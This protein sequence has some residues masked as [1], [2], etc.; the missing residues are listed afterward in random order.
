[1]FHQDLFQRGCHVLLVENN[2]EEEDEPDQAE[3]ED[4]ELKSALNINP[5]SEPKIPSSIQM[6]T[7]IVK[8]DK[9]RPQVKKNP[10][11]KSLSPTQVK[12]LD[13]KDKEIVES[14]EKDGTIKKYPPLRH[15]PP[16]PDHQD[17]S[18]EMEGSVLVRRK[19]MKSPESELENESVYIAK[20]INFDSPYRDKENIIL[21]VEQKVNL[22]HTIAV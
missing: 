18:R 13:E 10:V 14:L 3:K 17:S 16:I 20:N 12:I 7:G 22:I 5:K 1:M 9:S 2:N 21:N 4:F 11:E 6:P 19:R 15:S 8:N